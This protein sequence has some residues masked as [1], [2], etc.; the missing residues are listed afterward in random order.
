VVVVVEVG[1]LCVPPTNLSEGVPLSNWRNDFQF[2]NDV[3][4]RP[5]HLHGPR[6]WLAR[7]ELPSRRPTLRRRNDERKR[8]SHSGSPPATVEGERRTLSQEKTRMISLPDPI[9]FNW[10][11]ACNVVPPF[12]RSAACLDPIHARVEFK[13]MRRSEALPPPRRHDNEANETGR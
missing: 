6:F 10:S 2:I 9:Q 8:K 13:S 4:G 11:R 12:G 7:H 1:R 3:G 5:V